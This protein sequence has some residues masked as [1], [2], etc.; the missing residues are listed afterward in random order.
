MT[1]EAERFEDTMPLTL[2]PKGAEA[3][4]CKCPLEMSKDSKHSPLEPP[5]EAK[6][7]Q[8]PDPSPGRLLAHL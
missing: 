4:E 5:K 7:C 1:E 2:T 3:K 8:C 6:S